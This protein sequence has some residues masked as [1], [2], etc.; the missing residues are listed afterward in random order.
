MADTSP[1]DGP[2]AR[3]KRYWAFGEGAARW[4]TF[5]ELRAVLKKYVPAPELDG[6]TASIYHLRYGVWPGK[7][8]GDK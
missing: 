3:L 5:T 7:K 6:L 2:A 8:R 4:T 1:G